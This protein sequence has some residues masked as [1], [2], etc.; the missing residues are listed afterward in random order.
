M[1]SPTGSSTWDMHRLARRAPGAWQTPSRSRP[2][3]KD[4]GINLIYEDGNQSQERQIE[5][6][7]RFIEMEVDVIVLS[8]VV[9]SGWDEVLEEAQ[10][11]GIPVSFPTGRSAHKRTICI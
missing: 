2:R 6:L 7:R 11:A 3:A 1:K 8:P 9:D 10:D 4:F 5:A